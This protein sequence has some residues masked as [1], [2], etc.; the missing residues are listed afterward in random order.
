VADRAAAGGQR[1]ALDALADVV[2]RVDYTARQ[3]GEALA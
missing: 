2:L 1:F 3:G